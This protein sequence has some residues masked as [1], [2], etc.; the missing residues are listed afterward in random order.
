[1]YATYIYIIYYC[2]ICTG[3]GIVVLCYIPYVCVRLYSVCITHEISKISIKNFIISI[4]S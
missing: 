3:P 4:I 2:T 1:M